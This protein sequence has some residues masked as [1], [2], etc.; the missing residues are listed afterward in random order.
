MAG[1]S[2]PR[3]RVSRRVVVDDEEGPVERRV[4]QRR[5]QVEEYRVA[6]IVE[7]DD[8]S[9]EV[10]VQLSTLANG[11]VIPDVGAPKLRKLSADDVDKWLAEKAKILSTRTLQDVR[12]ILQRSVARA[13]AR[14]KVKR[15]VVL[16][17]DLPTGQPGRPSK[18][19]NFDQA[20][21]LLAAAEV[22][23]STIGCLHCRVCCP[24]AYRG[25]ASTHMV[26]RRLGR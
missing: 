7:G 25:N 21:A 16:L 2:Q 4:A 24:G 15:N 12:P 3:D 18:S 13:Q 19:L 10:T 22:N 20:E 5:Q 1:Q 9:V 17:R 8:L 11:H 23:D 26:A 14:D 6:A